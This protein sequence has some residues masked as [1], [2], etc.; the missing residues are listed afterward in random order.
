[1][2]SHLDEFEQNFVS[3]NKDFNVKIDDLSRTSNSYTFRVESG[4]IKIP[5][6]G[7]DLRTYDL[8]ILI[9]TDGQQFN[10]DWMRINNNPEIGLNLSSTLTI[11]ATDLVFVTELRDT[12][13]QDL[14]LTFKISQTASFAGDKIAMQ[15]TVSPA[16]IA[17]SQRQLQSS[18]NFKQLGKWF[19]RPSR[20][21]ANFESRNKTRRKAIVHQWLDFRL[22]R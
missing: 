5:L 20:V 8:E 12:S 9:D 17:P 22:K 11:R 14:T 10:V 2:K 21:N 6:K 1:M 16:S 13:T 19:H 3:S 4:E 15:F 7:F 18:S